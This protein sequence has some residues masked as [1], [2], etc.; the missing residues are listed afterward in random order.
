MVSNSHHERPSE[1]IADPGRTKIGQK[2]PTDKQEQRQGYNAE[3]LQKPY[4]GYDA[5]MCSTGCPSSSR[6]YSGLLPWSGGSAGYCSGLPA[7]SLLP[8]P[9]HQRSR[10]PP[11]IG[12]VGGTLC[13]LWLY[14]HKAH[15][16]SVVGYSVWNWLQLTLR[17]LPRVYSDTFYCSLKIVLFSNAR[18]GSAS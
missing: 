1:V 8:Q 4:K 2:A 3:Q 6:S 7:R 9:G 5:R 10:F 14:F 15:V 11:L 13:S 16:F 12:T 17:L 18:I